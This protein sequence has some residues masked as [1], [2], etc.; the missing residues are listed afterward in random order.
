MSG[1]EGGSGDGSSDERG[2][3]LS[4][5]A[6]R[7]AL[8]RCPAHRAAFSLIELVSVMAIIIV[9]AG[10]LG[11]LLRG[12]G[13]ESYGLQTAQNTVASLLSLARSQAALQGRDA[14]V[15]LHT[16]PGNRDRYL[17]F[18]IPV[19]RNESDTDWEILSEGVYLPQG[20]YALSI[21]TPS[22]TEVEAGASW[23]TIRSS[24]LQTDG[25]LDFEHGSAES[26]KGT[27]ISPRGTTGDAGNIVVATGRPQPDG[28]DPAFVFTN[29]ENIR[30]IKLSVYGQLTFLNNREDLSP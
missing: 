12:R 15:F 17:K 27:V 25:S 4:S 26:Y 13:T 8:P 18:F 11:Y 9:M 16:D 22:G 3:G 1:Q 30:A 10:L 28:L 20:C 6:C 2:A 14:G 5:P 19:V 21:S 24:A 23:G 7:L 29:P